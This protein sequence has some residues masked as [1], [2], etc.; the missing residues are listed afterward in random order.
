[1]Q[2]DLCRHENFDSA[3]EDFRESGGGMMYDF[4]YHA[5]FT[6][7]SEALEARNDVP[8]WHQTVA[9]LALGGMDRFAIAD[10]LMDWMA[11]YIQPK[12]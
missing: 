1:M 4:F 2:N 7:S 11:K 5:W 8:A 12:S 6:G 9:A 3:L 10:E